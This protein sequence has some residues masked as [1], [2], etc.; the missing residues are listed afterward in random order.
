MS[1]PN[2]HKVED[3]VKLFRE[4]FPKSATLTHLILLPYLVLELA[5]WDHLPH[6]QSNLL[7]CCCRQIPIGGLLNYYWFSPH[8]VC[9]LCHHIYVLLMTAKTCDGIL[10]YCFYEW[11]YHYHLF[12]RIFQWVNFMV[13][14]FSS[15][16]IS[17][18]KHLRLFLRGGQL[19]A[20]EVCSIL[21]LCLRMKI[22][23]F[24]SS[25]KVFPGFEDMTPY[26]L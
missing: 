19:L 11:A 21:T 15:H 3:F 14:P 1:F 18:L 12:I 2:F 10:T 22:K 13:K 25:Q 5:P 16:F 20:L 9:F 24:S 6:H 8:V 7:R 17:G 26:A 23:L 4:Y